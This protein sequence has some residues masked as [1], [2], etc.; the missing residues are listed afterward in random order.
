MAHGQLGLL[1]LLSGLS[2]VAGLVRFHRY[3]LVR[4]GDGFQYRAG[5]GTIKSRGF[6]RYKLQQVTVTQGLM[7]RLMK[8]FSLSVSKAGDHTATP[9][10]AQQ[11]FLVPVLTARTLAALSEQLQLPGPRWRS[12]NAVCVLGDTLVQGSF[13]ALLIGTLLLIAGA[14]VWPALLVYPAVALVGLRRWQRLAY[15]RGDGWLALRTGFVGR[16]VQW[17]PE[18]KVQK[19]AVSRPPW[20]RSLGLCH[21][22]VWGAAGR[23][24]IPFLA[25]GEGARLSESLLESVTRYRGRWF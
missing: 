23:L 25:E 3:Q 20:L 12:V 13:L 14:V 24:T 19:V 16:K 17:L 9:S 2:I 4:R 6:R 11:K 10:K 8:R 1:M 7:A 22:T 21:L 18:A 15:H 5:L